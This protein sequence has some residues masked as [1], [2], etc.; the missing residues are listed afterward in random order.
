MLE[1]VN[2][3]TDISPSR[4]NQ[5]QAEFKSDVVG[6]LLQS[7]VNLTIISLMRDDSTLHLMYIIVN[8]DSYS[9]DSIVIW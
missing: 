3:P 6:N 5:S 1:L 2:R 7:W 9:C 8:A 4:A